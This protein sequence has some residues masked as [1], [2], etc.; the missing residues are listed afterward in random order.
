MDRFFLAA[1]KI[2]REAAEIVAYEPP[3]DQPSWRDMGIEVEDGEEAE[4]RRRGEVKL[5]PPKDR[6]D[7]R[8]AR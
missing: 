4:A 7:P 5:R 2:L 1:Q 6:D 8:S 3:E